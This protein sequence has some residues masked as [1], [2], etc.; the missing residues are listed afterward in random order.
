V[1]KIVFLIL[2]LIIIIFAVIKLNN[3]TKEGSVILKV[4]E[5]IKLAKENAHLEANKIFMDAIAMFDKQGF[6]LHKQ[7]ITEFSSLL[8]EFKTENTK[9]V[10]MFQSLDPEL[11]NIINS[12]KASKDITSDILERFC[13]NINKLLIRE[14]F[15]SSVYTDDKEKY[16]EFK[17]RIVAEQKV[18]FSSSE[19][20]LS[21]Q[22]TN[23]LYL[24]HLFKSYFLEP[25]SRNEIILNSALALFSMGDYINC[26]KVLEKVIKDNNLYVKAYILLSRSYEKTKGV[27]DSIALLKNGLEN[28]PSNEKLLT[29]IAYYYNKS[30]RNP[31]ATAS[32]EK[33]LE[34]N[35]SYQYALAMRNNMERDEV[36]TL[37]S[38]A[39]YQHKLDKGDKSISNLSNL[40]LALRKVNNV[41]ECSRIISKGRELFP[42]DSFFM[43][44]QGWIEASK[45][46]YKNAVSIL[47][48]AKQ[49]INQSDPEIFLLLGITYF[50][51][52][53]EEEAYDILK[54]GVSLF[55]ED[56]S[57][58]FNLARICEM[59]SIHHKES[60]T[61]YQDFLLK[62]K[63]NKLSLKIQ[64]KIENLRKKS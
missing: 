22:Y 3:N 26:N 54:Q 7:D 28:A 5:G 48:K 37:K 10:K 32:L 14:D 39:F 51:Q 19:R 36:K 45:K 29:E 1:K 52:N 59:S 24:S 18:H 17:H 31:E 11:Q 6:K 43:K 21:N 27:E 50:N 61:F 20:V 46:N 64:K 44:M 41:E 56:K 60:I 4:R 33:A 25:I 49:N 8:N 23:R 9:Y 58:L 38:A 57:I 55:P 13:G 2:L 16:L 34:V 53:L 30:G 35:P 63:D 62:F 40:S 15:Y 12:L 47:L 42:N